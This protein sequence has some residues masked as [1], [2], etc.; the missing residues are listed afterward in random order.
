MKKIS[1]KSKLGQHFVEAYIR[2]TR[3]TLKDAYVKPSSAK[4]AVFKRCQRQCEA[5]KGDGLKVISFNCN[6]F[7]VAF[8]VTTASG[9]TE[10]RVITKRNDYVIP[11]G[12][13]I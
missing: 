7:T 11:F 6:Q 13:K 8:E 4:Q 12:D 5:E 9:A 10:L 1:A 2:S 3:H